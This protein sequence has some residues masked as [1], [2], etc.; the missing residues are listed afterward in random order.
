[1]KAHSQYRNGPSDSAQLRVGIVA[2]AKFTLNALGNFVDVLRLASDD[3]DRS[4]SIRCQWYIMSATGAPLIA[5]CGCELNP[6]SS[7]MDFRSLDYIAVIGGLLYRGQPIDE[8]VRSYLL[9]AGEA[10]VPLLGI[11]TGSFVLCRLGLMKDRKCCVSWYHYRDFVR[12]FEDVPAISDEL[13]VV[14]GNRITSSGGVGAALTAAFLVERHLDSN[15]ARKALHI[16][17]IDKARPG[18]TL[19]PAPPLT[20]SGCDERVTRALLMMERNISNP[21][22]ITQLAARAHTT[23]RTL[24]RLFRKHLG[25][26]PLAA[27]LTIR[28]THAELKVRDGLRMGMIAAETGFSSAAQLSSALTRRRRRMSSKLGDGSSMYRL[29]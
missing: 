16:M 6:T 17:Q 21:V 23:V 27:Y 7:L 22:P 12:E 11:C 9:V 3:G 8:S 4:R 29:A 26:A 2:T 18:A 1:M 15:C 5:S 19:Q 24:Q 20:F 13:Y 25:I 10:G 14:D 28:L